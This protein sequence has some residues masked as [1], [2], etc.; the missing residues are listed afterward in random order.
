MKLL[1]TISTTQRY[2]WQRTNTEGTVFR[3]PPPINPLPLPSSTEH[4]A[5]LQWACLAVYLTLLQCIYTSPTQG[6]SSKPIKH[7]IGGG[8]GWRV[9]LCVPY[10]LSLPPLLPFLHKTEAKKRDTP[11]LKR[12]LPCC[13][14]GPPDLSVI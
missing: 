3:N 7:S 12:V 10:T 5:G 4:Q 11:L 6:N 14:E 9:S 8:V 13:C 2:P 1:C